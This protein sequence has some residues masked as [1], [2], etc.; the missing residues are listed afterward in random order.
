MAT[1]QAVSCPYIND[2]SS[3]FPWIP[4]AVPNHI[5]EELS[6]LHG[7]P[8][9]WFA[10]QLASY[11]MRPKFDTSKEMKIFNNLSESPVVGIHVRRTDKVSNR[12]SKQ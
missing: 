3:S 2:I 11:L 1:E 8:F 10:G 9:I 6:H 5:S 4:P 7:A 12:Q